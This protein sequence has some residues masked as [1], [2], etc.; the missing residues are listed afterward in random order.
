MIVMDINELR[1]ILYDL[2]TNRHISADTYDDLL[3]C[4]LVYR[5]LKGED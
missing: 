5:E 1:S 2:R 3:V 4:V